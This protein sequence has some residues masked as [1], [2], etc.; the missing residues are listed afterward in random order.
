MPEYADSMTEQEIMDA[1]AA[2]RYASE[3][4][5]RISESHDGIERSLRRMGDIAQATVDRMDFDDRA[6]KLEYSPLNL[7]KV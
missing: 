7:P 2:L 5:D 1:E 6:P 4:L 3:V